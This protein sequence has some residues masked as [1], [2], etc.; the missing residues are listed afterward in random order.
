MYVHLFSN[1]MASNILTNS[2]SKSLAIKS[3]IKHGISYLHVKIRK[4]GYKTFEK[5]SSGNYI[6][7]ISS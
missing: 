3:H 6:R 1:F 5:M 2:L 7:E 4:C